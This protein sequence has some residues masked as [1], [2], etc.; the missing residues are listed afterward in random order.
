MYNFV[1]KVKSYLLFML[2]SFW[3]RASDDELKYLSPLFHS[4]YLVPIL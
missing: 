3:F 4:G 1:L 2:I